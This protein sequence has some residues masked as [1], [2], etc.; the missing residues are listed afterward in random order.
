[1][2]GP[3]FA[4]PW[5]V[6]SRHRWAFL[7][8]AGTLLAMAVA[9]PL[10]FA[11]VSEPAAVL[12]SVLP[13][14]VVFGFLMNALLFVDDYGSVAAGYPRRM[15]ALPVSTNTLVAWP[16]L[17]GT[18][19]MALLWLAAGLVYR[20]SGF[21]TP[22]LLPAL[23]LAA[24]LAWMQAVSWSPISPPWMQLVLAVAL[25]TVLGAPPLWLLATERAAE[26]TVAILL[27]GYLAAA[28]VVARAGVA[29]ARHGGEWQLPL[30]VPLP[31]WFGRQAT[32]RQPFRSAARAQLWY[33]WRS[34]GL[35]LPLLAG[36]QIVLFQGYF[37]FQRDV[38]LRTAA[39]LLLMI[40]MLMA[41]TMGVNLARMGPFWV[42]ANKSFPFAATRPMNSG[43]LIAA[44]FRMAALSVLLTWAVGIG[45]TLLLIVVSGR[46]G[47]AARWWGE[48]LGGYP[49]WK[50]SAIL[51]LGAVVVPAM[52]WRM[53]TDG[54]IPGLT[55]R[56]WVASLVAVLQCALF[57]GGGGGWLW[58]VGHPDDRQRF[59]AALPWLVVSAAAV[60]AAVSAWAFRANLARGLMTPAALCAVLA[61]WLLLVAC[62]VGLVALLAPAE[63]LPVSWPIVLLGI[64]TFT[65]LA[66]F[67][68][69]PL[70]LDWNRHR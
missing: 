23:G 59:L 26:S 19:V 43:A 2:R 34:H 52:T 11:R 35:S 13:P 22:L 24:V 54:V 27:A 48:A 57:L 4:I 21:E 20:V 40:P 69:A 30:R 58:L 25:L 31:R 44:K 61:G 41:G 1:M 6:W 47:T 36:T 42:P 14:V 29:R 70:A 62:T 63:G 15:L 51:A 67:A 8:S 65:P 68:L 39:T 55:G 49:A 33:E 66:R 7:A 16:M 37:L 9:Y 17:Y 46:V 5:G 60:K 18:V 3:A 10:L 45:A 64:A 28:F 12:A 38:D 32:R 50:A 56:S 53:A